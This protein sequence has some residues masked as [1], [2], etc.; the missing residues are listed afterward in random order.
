MTSTPFGSSFI[1]RPANADAA[2]VAFPASLATSGPGWFTA[3]VLAFAAICLGQ[4]LQVNYGQFHPIAIRW[5]TLALVA[6]LAAAALANFGRLSIAGWRPD[7]FVLAIGLWVQFAMLWASVPVATLKPNTADDL[8]PFKAG[9]ALAAALVAVGVSQTRVAKVAVPLVLLAHLLLGVW[10]IHATPAPAVDVYVFQRDAADALLRGENPYAI[11]FPDVYGG[12]GGGGV[13]NHARPV[14][15]E[16]IAQHGRLNFGYPYLPLSLF[17]TLPGHVLGDFRYAHLLALTLAGALI[18]Y[19]RP[20]GNAIPSAR[21]VAAAAVL[22]FTPRG[23][24]VVEAGWIEPVAILMLAA[25]VFCACRRGRMWGIALAV[26]LGLLLASKQYLVLA[27]PLVLLIP[28]DRFEMPRHLIGTIAMLVAVTVTL[29]LASW[30]ARAFVHSAVTLQ[31]HQPFRTDALS[32]LVT[33]AGADGSVPPPPV[34]IAFACAAVAGLLALW[35]CPRTASGFA[36]GV[37]VVFFAFFATRKQ[38]F[39]NYYAFVL[40]AMCCALAALP[41]VCPAPQCAGERTS[42]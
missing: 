28:A 34:W 11:T 1:A 7:Q 15:G 26:A 19:A 38:A 2:P 30:D 14:Y 37:A 22:L 17:L 33:F 6:T 12:G 42:Q 10:V 32:F 25:V 8:A 35:R 18:A 3:T 16:G 5:L 9:V 21:A 36:T 40:A 27:L 24:F 20:V 39:C 4:A 31:F 41:G 23:F 29:P 13:V